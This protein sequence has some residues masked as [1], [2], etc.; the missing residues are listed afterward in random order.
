MSKIKVYELAK[1]LDVPSKDV[2]EFLGSNNIEVKNHMSTLEEADAKKVRAAMGG[3]SKSDD[4]KEA[5]EAPK[6]KNIVHVFRPQNTQNGNKP[7]R[8]TGG[9][10]QSAQQGRPMQVNNGRPSKAAALAKEEKE[11]VKRPITEKPAVEKPAEK[12]VEKP[13]EKAAA[14]KRAEA[15]RP[16]A[17]KRPEREDRRPAREDDRRQNRGGERRSERP[18]ENNCLLYTS[19]AADEL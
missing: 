19:D 17:E 5:K 12:P 9:N 3:A 10:R 1:E 6:K 14:P 13:I 11:V 16:A 7:G 2:L 15:Q 4:E 18:Q 8:R